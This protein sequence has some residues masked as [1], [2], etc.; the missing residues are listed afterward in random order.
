MTAQDNL[1][2]ASLPSKEEIRSVVFNLDCESSLDL[3]D[4]SGMFFTCYWDIIFDD[5]CNDVHDI[6]AGVWL[7]MF[8]ASTL[9]ILIPKVP[10]PSTFV[11]FD[12]SVSVV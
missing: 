5:V 11:D 7:P 12:P 9:I 10:N 3:D 2:L 8:L 4:F 1:Q 6:W